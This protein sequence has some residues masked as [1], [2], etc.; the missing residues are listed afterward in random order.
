MAA[1]FPL[2]RTLKNAKDATAKQE[3]LPGSVNTIRRKKKKKEK[4]T[5]DKKIKERVEKSGERGK[6]ALCLFP[7]FARFLVF[8]L[9]GGRPFN[10]SSCEREGEG[11]EG[12]LEEARYTRE[13]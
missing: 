6:T 7:L 13:L 12:R 4:V 3:F 5:K 2:A 10:A 9:S 1:G 11:R 8:F